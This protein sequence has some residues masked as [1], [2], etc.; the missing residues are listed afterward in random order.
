[1]DIDGAPGKILLDDITAPEGN[2]S[3]SLTPAA[4]RIGGSALY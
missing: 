2:M 1:M 3:F 4:L